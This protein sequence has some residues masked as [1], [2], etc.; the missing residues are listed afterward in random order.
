MLYVVYSNVRALVLTTPVAM[1]GMTS[2]K[3]QTTSLCIDAI[4][5]KKVVQLLVCHVETR[6]S[7]DNVLSRAPCA[8]RGLLMTIQSA[9]FAH[10]DLI[11]CLIG[12][13]VWCMGMSI[14]GS[15]RN[16]QMEVKMKTGSSA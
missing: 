15:C 1:V 4:D 5:S 13:L 9:R 8:V 6:A 16:F 14:V 10:G 3:E 2:K 11:A 12:L 7:F